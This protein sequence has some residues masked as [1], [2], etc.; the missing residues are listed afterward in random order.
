MG[1]NEQGGMLRTVVIVGI[2]AMLTLIIILSVLGL[3]N[4]MS[5]N[6]NSAVGAVV[7]TKSPYYGKD[8]AFTSYTSGQ[9]A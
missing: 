6:T 1:E 3:K 5:K 2:I 7:T 4:N 8:I 9:N